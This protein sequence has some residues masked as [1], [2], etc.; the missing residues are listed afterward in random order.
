LTGFADDLDPA[1]VLFADAINRGQAK[2]GAF[3]RFFGGEERLEDV[4]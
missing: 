2:T 3:A 1:L 4:R